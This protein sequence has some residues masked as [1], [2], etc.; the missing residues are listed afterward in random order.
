MRRALTLSAAAVAALAFGLSLRAEDKAIDIGGNCPNFQGLEA[1]DGKSYSL[2]D[3]KDKDVLVVCITC[4]HCPVAVGYEDRLIEFNK[5]YGGPDSK[6][7][8]LAINV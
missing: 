7:A 4:N 6:V 8:L 3:F 5:K 2:A 1:A